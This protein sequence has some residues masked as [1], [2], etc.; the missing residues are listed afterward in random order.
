VGAGDE[1]WQLSPQRDQRPVEV[2]DRFGIG[3]KINDIL[4]GEI[5][6]Q[7]QSGHAGRKPGVVGR[8]PCIGVRQPSRPTPIPGTFFSKGS[9]TSSGTIGT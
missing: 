2:E 9:R 8:I 4:V 7:R 5:V 6:G 3:I 1:L